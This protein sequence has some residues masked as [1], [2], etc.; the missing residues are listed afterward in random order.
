MYE[1]PPRIVMTA[2][3]I[4]V[5]MRATDPLSVSR[6]S[7]AITTT[8]TSAMSLVAPTE[9]SSPNEE[10]ARVAAKG[11]GDHDRDDLSDQVVEPGDAPGHVPVAEPLDEK[12]DRSSS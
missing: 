4:A 10:R 8:M 3:T 6:L 11:E 12:L 9:T 7:S 2:Q 1:K 5:W